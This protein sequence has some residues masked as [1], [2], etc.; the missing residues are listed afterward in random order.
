MDCRPPG[1]SVRGISYSRI[2]EWAAISFSIPSPGLIPACFAGRFFAPEPPGKSY[3]KDRYT[4]DRGFPSGSRVKNRPI[5]QETQETPVPL[6]GG[7]DPLKKEMETHSSIFARKISWTEK[8]GG[9]QSTGS[10]RIGHD[11]ARTHIYYKD[12]TEFIYLCLIQWIHVFN[13]I[14]REITSRTII[15]T[16]LLNILITCCCWCC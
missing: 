8:P 14:L 11:W 1:S 15:S 12:W 3:Y 9:L 10:Q 4:Y 2:L 13:C 7:E 16:I 5:M 6:M